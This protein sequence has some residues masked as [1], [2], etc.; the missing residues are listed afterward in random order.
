M[1][2]KKK[3]LGLAMAAAIALPASSAYAANSYTPV[4]GNSGDELTHTIDMQGS[5]HTAD[6][7]VAAGKIEVELPTAMAFTVNKKGE[8]AGAQ[9]KV[10]NRSQEKIQVVAENFR[11]SQQGIEIQTKQAIADDRAQTQND[12]KSYDRSNVALQL[13]GN[14]DVT[15]GVKEL[16]L[17]TILNNPSASKAICNVD[18]GKE[19]TI[20]LVGQAGNKTTS[21]E[22]EV[23]KKG[24]TGQF[25][26]VFKINSGNNIKDSN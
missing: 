7:A 1:A 26:L 12:S 3:F 22:N 20:N 14:M 18:A 15:P 24:A 16:D 9:Y 8:L 2:M 4:G 5:V 19:E 23:D 17:A 13:Q 11:V 10:T 25:T 21:G 6:G